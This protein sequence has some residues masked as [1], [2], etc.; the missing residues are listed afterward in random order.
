MIT[1][2][3]LL[4]V[5]IADHI[6][7]ISEVINGDTKIVTEFKRNEEGKLLKVRPFKMNVHVITY[8][9]IHCMVTNYLR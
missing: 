2:I 7:P 8:M 5:F 6:P 4:N 3:S 1:S 9:Y